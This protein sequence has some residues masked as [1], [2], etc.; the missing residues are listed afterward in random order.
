MSV[1]NIYA[2]KKGNSFC[3]QGRITEAWHHS[4]HEQDVFLFIHFS[5]QR[6]FEKRTEVP[7]KM[8]SNLG[9]LRGGAK[10]STGEDIDGWMGPPSVTWQ[11]DT[12]VYLCPMGTPGPFLLLILLHF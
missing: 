12:L 9:A 4:I 7:V 2:E 1:K 11:P 8:L 6:F 3:C 5:P 10:G